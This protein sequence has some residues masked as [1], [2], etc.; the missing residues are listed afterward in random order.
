[1]NVREET[2]P[3]ALKRLAGQAR[4]MFKIHCTFRAQG[5]IPSLPENTVQQLYKIAQEAVTN[6]I[7]HA[8][9]DKISIKLSRRGNTTLLTIRNNGLPFPSLKDQHPGVGLRIMHYRANLVNATLEVK[10]VGKGTIVNC[11]LPL[12]GEVE[13][14]RLGNLHS[15]VSE[16]AG[17]LSTD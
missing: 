10:P 9:A 5:K 14:S 2:L 15:R 8:K 3:S 1:L 17:T 16:K 12:R 4:T 7:R 6:A 11:A 13:L